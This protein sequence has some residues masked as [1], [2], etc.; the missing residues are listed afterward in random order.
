MSH[1]RERPSSGYDD[2]SEF[3]LFYDSVPVYG[4]RRDVQFYVARAVEA[5][6]PILELGC[7]T[8]R[9][10]IPSA[11][12]SRQPI[13]GLDSSQEMLSR[14]REK[15]A[16]EPADVRS[17]VTLRAG[18]VRDF[19]L[20]A[21][22][23]LV[24]APF[25]VIQHLT[26]IEDQLQFLASVRRHLRPDGLLIFDVFNPLMKALAS[27]RSSEQAEVPPQSLPDGRT[28]SRSVRVP[29]VRWVDQVSEIELIYYVTD[30]R[31][32]E[33]IRHVKAFEMRWYQHAELHHLIARAGF[34]VISIE[35]DF[36]GAPLEDGAPEQ[37]VRCRPAK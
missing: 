33:T 9:V 20:G 19:D 7:G 16:N 32:G 30:P 17:R 18:D 22:F 8:G 2:I 24:T 15:L 5:P 34:D 21:S 6:G 28:M 27:D 11:R 4:T 12:A 36:D 23:A 13:V 26:T 37:V 25:R 3:G 31:S 10:L 29:R 35:G 14:C 1:H